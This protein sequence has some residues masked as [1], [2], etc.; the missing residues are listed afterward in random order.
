MPSA[1]RT[2]KLDSDKTR[3][4]TLSAQWQRMAE[5]AD[6]A[7]RLPTQQSQSSLHDLKQLRHAPPAN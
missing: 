1:S 7:T 2:S 6:P 5:E 3:W 4:L